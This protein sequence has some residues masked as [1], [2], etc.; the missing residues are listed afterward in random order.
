MAIEFLDDSDPEVVIDAATMLGQNGS[1]G[2]EEAL[3]RRIEKWRREW[4]GREQELK[5]DFHVDNPIRFQT[6]IEQALRT[7]LS[8]SPAWL[9]D[10]KKLERLKSLCVTQNERQQIGQGRTFSYYFPVGPRIS[11]PAAL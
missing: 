10:L 3:W 2:A 6:G 1:D 4:N 5:V 9:A 7:A 11:S 8:N